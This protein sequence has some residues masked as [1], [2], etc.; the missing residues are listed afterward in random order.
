MAKRKRKVLG[1]VLDDQVAAG[2]G[3]PT[4]ITT[5]LGIQPRV[6]TKTPY[7][8]LLPALS[9]EERQ[10]LRQSIKERGVD[11]PVVVAEDGTVLDGHHRLA[12]NP[13]APRR[14]LLGLKTEPEKRAAAYRLNLARRHL[15]AEQRG[16]VLN[17]MKVTALA[18]NREGKTQDQV[19][20]LLGVSREAVK[21]WFGN[22]SV[23][24]GPGTKANRW[25]KA[26][27]KVDPET[28]RAIVQKVKA[29][30]AVGKVAFRYGVT[31]GRVSQIVKAAGKPKPLKAKAVKPGRRVT[32]PH[33]R[34][35]FTVAI[36]S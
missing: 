10:T 31:H 1:S 3:L 36:R 13:K 2:L 23:S 21:K 12:V 16:K 25:R 9:G 28:R 33:C 35:A 32:C 20:A 4:P 19:A 7:K 27:A 14:V 6:K 5:S 18:L 29:G 34:R 24:N 17:G 22:S 11:I 26:S 30:Q 15:T 8:R